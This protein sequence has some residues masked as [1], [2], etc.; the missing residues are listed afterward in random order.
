M[1]TATVS[2]LSAGGATPNG[3]TVTFSD[4]N[5]AI[6]SE[7]LVDGV[8]A[9]TTSSLPAGTTT[10]TASYGGTASFAASATGTIVTA[11]GNGTAGYAGNNGPATAAELDGPRGLAFDSA[12]NLFIADYGNNVVREVVKATGD[13]IAVAGNGTAGYSGDNGRA[14]AAELNGPRFVAFDSAGDL[15]LSDMNNNVVREVVKATGDIITV[16]GNGTAGY[17]GDDGPATA[18]ELNIPSGLALDL[19]GDLFIADN[20]NNTVREVVKATGDIITIAGNGIAGYR[21]D[22][23]PATAAELNVPGKVAVDSAGDL[24][25]ADVG[26]NVVREF[27]P[28][29]IVIVGPTTSPTPTITWPNPADIVYGTALGAAQ[30]DASANVPGTFTYSSP[31]GTVLKAGDGQTLSV[32]FTPTDTADYATTSATATISVLQATPTITWSNP[33]DITSG[34][35]LGATQLDATASYTVGGISVSV[36]GTFVYTPAAGTVLYGGNGQTLSVSFTPTDST[37]Y[38]TASATATINVLPES[39]KPVSHTRTVLTAKPRPA[40]LGRPVTLTA[41]VKNLNHGGGTPIGSI[42]FLD[43]T[44]NLSTVPLRH[45]KASLKISS[46]QLGPNTIQAEYT[47]SQGFAPGSAAINET[48]RA[49]RSRG[50]PAS[51]PESAPGRT[52]PSTAVAIRDGG[53]AMPSGAITIIGSPTVLGPLGL[54]QGSAARRDGIPTASRHIR[55]ATAR[56]GNGVPSRAVRPTQA[57]NQAIPAPFKL[58]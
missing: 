49:R 57:V 4:Q 20:G 52:V 39:G 56:T 10:V 28:A 51:F 2:D 17:R 15:F 21:G 32:I 7:T 33:A 3:G 14:T 38:T 12:G 55:T 42:T 58:A 19:V 27:S 25:I 13:I 5:G 18:A 30:L 8:A 43:G 44:V 34:T 47:P 24:F 45:G 26:N 6:G 35:A 41:T 1:F 22:G 46:L 50:K 37:D 54:D 36:A 9:F 29:V 23:G 48:V 53:A 40:N 16:A 11:A 31:A